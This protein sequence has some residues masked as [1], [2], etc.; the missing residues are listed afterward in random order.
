MAKL[1]DAMNTNICNS[2]QQDFWEWDLWKEFSVKQQKNN[3]ISLI[4]VS[5]FIGGKK[6]Y[7]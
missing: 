6:K 2:I 4:L 1:K 3:D 7:I 5:A